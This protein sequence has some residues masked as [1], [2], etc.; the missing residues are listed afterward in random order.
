MSEKCSDAVVQ[1]CLGLE[2]QFFKGKKYE[3]FRKRKVGKINI[4]SA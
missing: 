1:A 2:K 3:K 4:V